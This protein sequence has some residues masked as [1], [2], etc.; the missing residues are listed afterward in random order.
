VGAEALGALGSELSPS[1]SNAGAP[2]A[3]HRLRSFPRAFCGE[4]AAWVA[5]SL[6]GALEAEAVGCVGQRGVGAEALGAL[7]SELSPSFSNAG[8]HR[9]HTPP[10]MQAFG[11]ASSSPARPLLRVG[12][13]VARKFVGEG[14]GW[15][16]SPFQDSRAL[17]RRGAH[18]E[19]WILPPSTPNGTMQAC[20]AASSPAA[21]PLLRVGQW[22][23]RKFV[24]EGIGWAHSP[25]Q[26]SRALRRR[27]AHREP[28]TLPPSTPNGTMQA[29]GAASSP[30]ALDGRRVSE[31]APG[32]QLH[33][34]GLLARACAHKMKLSPPAGQTGWSRARQR[35]AFFTHTARNCFPGAASVRRGVKCDEFCVN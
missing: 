22:V 35:P 21:R 16:H 30:A 32:G 12:Q 10:T 11:A 34:P 23:A 15:A 27:G 28:W 20:G 2:K 29:F 26:D 33:C 6:A 31:G 13:W 17:R 7:G 3:H 19:P 24:G 1:F 5:V 14:I 25:F 4:P 9:K 8:A 18:R